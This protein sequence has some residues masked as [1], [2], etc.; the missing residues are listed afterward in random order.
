MRVCPTAHARAGA[1][2]HIRHWCA[3]LASIIYFFA[4]SSRPALHITLIVILLAIT[5]PVTTTLLACAALFAAGPRPQRSSRKAIA[6]E[7]A[8]S[9]A[10]H[11]GRPFRKVKGTAARRLRNR[12]LIISTPSE[13]AIAK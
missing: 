10:R 5:A 1:G 6:L 4:L 8:D 11:H 13:N 3:A 7:T 2:D 9:N 12:M